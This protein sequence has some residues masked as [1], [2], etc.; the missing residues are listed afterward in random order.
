MTTQAI[1]YNNHRWGLYIKSFDSNEKLKDFFNLLA[2]SVDKQGVPFAA[3]V[4]GMKLD[5]P[6]LFYLKLF[7]HSSPS[8]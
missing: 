6:F 8:I 1:T 4:E 7:M 3:A 2:L 5:F